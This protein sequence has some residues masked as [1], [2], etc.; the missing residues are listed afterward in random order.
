MS[1]KTMMQLLEKTVKHSISVL[2]F[3]WIVLVAHHGIIAIDA[4]IEILD[5]SLVWFWI[6]EG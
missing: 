5:Q 1:Q 4:L 3:A 6:S 2:V